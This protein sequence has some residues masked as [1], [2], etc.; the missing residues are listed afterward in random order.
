MVK[1]FSK[2]SLNLINCVTFVLLGRVH[3]SWIAF[4]LLIGVTFSFTF[5]I[6]L[7]SNFPETGTPCSHFRV[8]SREP[9]VS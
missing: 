4:F 1:L 2:N 7:R 3:L 8:Q 6:E 5:E 9:G